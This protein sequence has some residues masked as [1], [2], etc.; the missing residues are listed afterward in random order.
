MDNILKYKG[1]LG[2]FGYEEG[3]DALHGVVINVNDV[4]HFQGRTIPELRQSFQDSVD[5]YLSWCAEEGKEPEKPFSGKFV[6]RLDPEVHRKISTQAVQQ[7]KSLN[8]WVV[9]ALEEALG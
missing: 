6:V 5:D 8:Q 9:E 3:D 4:I 2:K 7:E 1:Y